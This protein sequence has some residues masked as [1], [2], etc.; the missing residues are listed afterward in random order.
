LLHSPGQSADFVRV[1]RLTIPGGDSLE[2]LEHASAADAT[3]WTL[4][5]RLLGYKAHKVLGE[6][7]HAGGLVS[8]YHATRAHHRSGG[9]QR[10]KVH[11][12]IQVSFRQ[13]AAQRPTRLH[14]FELPASRDAASHIVNNLTQGD[15]HGHFDQPGAIDHPAQGKD[16]SPGAALGTQPL[17]PVRP[18]PDDTRRVCIGLDVVDVAGLA[19]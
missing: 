7:D 18:H 12:N 1:F 11:R 2:N 13:A 10:V 16:G 6:L 3:R 9:I 4:A 19:P 15:A 17:K 8:H 5:A 14:S